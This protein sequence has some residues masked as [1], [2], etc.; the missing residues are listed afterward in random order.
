MSMESVTATPLALKPGAA[1]RLTAAVAVA[2][3]VACQKFMLIT[4]N[5]LYDRI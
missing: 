5:P 4:R 3:P 2:Q 1:Q